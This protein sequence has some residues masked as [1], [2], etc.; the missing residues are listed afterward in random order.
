M[1]TFSLVVKPTTIQTVLILAITKPWIIHQLDVKNVFL[2]GNL[3][4]TIY[5]H[6]PMGFCDPLHPNHMCLLKNSLY[7]LKQAPHVWYTRFVN[8]VSTIG[9]IHSQC[10]H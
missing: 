9:F 3:N 10:D 7:G 8:Y 6:Q 1:E 4:E 2:H 5:M